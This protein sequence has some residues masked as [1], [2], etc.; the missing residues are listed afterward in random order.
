MDTVDHLFVGAGPAALCLGL[1]LARERPG[2]TMAFVDPFDPDD[3]ERTFAYWS[4]GPTP[5][6]PHAFA[7]WDRLAV[8]GTG[9]QRVLPLGAWRYR[10]FTMGAFRRA[11]RDTL[12][13]AGAR[14]ITGTVEKLV[15]AEQVVAHDLRAR[16]AYDS[17]PWTP[18]DPH[19][20]V[21][22]FAGWWLHTEEPAFDPAV[23]TLMDFR[24]SPDL[25]EAIAFSY[26]LP[27]S[28]HDALLMA[29]TMAEGAAE[30][31][32][33]HAHTQ[34]L[35]IHSYRV[36]AHEAGSLPMS[37]APWPREAS[38]HVL[39]I[40]AAGG[41]LKPSTGYGITRMADDADRIVA[42]LRAW[43]HPFALPRPKARE[44][45]ADRI[46]LRGIARFPDEAP[47]WFDTLFR[48][49]PVDRLLR[50][51]DGASTWADQ[52]AVMEALPV[53]RFRGLVEPS[54]LGALLRE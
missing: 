2:D 42:S 54:D 27:T 33:L 44:R 6:D 25:P 3:D 21:Q 36:R 51:L 39:R 9:G 4:N 46:F 32:P 13:A 43:G 26:V 53:R 20:L 35:G 14:W 19:A 8:Q 31:E 49:V 24:P 48:D 52:L 7:S 12:V 11:A 37:A 45:L 40:G 18:P 22:R 38:P 41:L 17:R 50:F 30:P 10:A 16:W 23:P 28:P 29:V 1:A 47:G 34:R 5:F 15:D